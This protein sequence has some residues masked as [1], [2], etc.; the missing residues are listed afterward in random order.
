[1]VSKEDIKEMIHQAGKRAGRDAVEGIDAALEAKARAMILDA[2]RNAD[3]A[4]RRTIRKEDLT[5][6]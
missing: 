4:G 3:F 2:K 6:I 1:M 5:W